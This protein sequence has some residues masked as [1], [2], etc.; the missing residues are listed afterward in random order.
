MHKVIKMKKPR[1]FSFIDEFVAGSALISSKEEVEWLYA[2]G[3]RT[4]ISLVEPNEEVRESMEELGIENLLFPVEDFEAPPIEV[5]AR[6]VEILRERGRRGE[7]VLVHCFAGC[8]RTGTLLACYLISKG[9]RPDDALSYLSS[10]RS[11]SLE[12]QAQYNA[13]WHY[14]SYVSRSDRL[15]QHYYGE[16]TDQMQR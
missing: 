11:C 16:Y 12:S 6:I 10:K 5:L 9:M 15:G 1:N 4:V 7:R 8:G 2:N 3:F 13:L 14:Y